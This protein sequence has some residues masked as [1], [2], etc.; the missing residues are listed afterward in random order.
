MS[1]THLVLFASLAAVFTLVTEAQ[2]GKKLYVGNLPFS[3]TDQFGIFDP[4]SSPATELQDVGISLNGAHIGTLQNPGSPLP[5]SSSLGII[6]PGPDGLGDAGF[7][8]V[9]Y[10]GPAGDFPASSFFDVFTEITDPNTG[11]PAEMKNGVVKFF[12]E[13]KGFGMVISGQVPGEPEYF[14]SLTGEINPAQVGLSFADVSVVPGGGPPA[15]SF[16]DIFTELQ[17]DGPGTIDPSLPLFRVTLTPV[18]EP[19]TLVLAAVGVAALISVVRKRR[20]RT[21]VFQNN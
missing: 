18:P 11:Q 7:F 15:N 14:Y 17:F 20:L 21:Q 13:T 12:N 5:A 6:N 10:D 19:S 1:R 4:S 8:D 3:A 9:F 2:A 16:F